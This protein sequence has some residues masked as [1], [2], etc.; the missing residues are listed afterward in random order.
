MQHGKKIKDIESD[1]KSATTTF[2]DGTKETGELIIGAE[3]AHSIVRDY[4]LGN[5]KAALVPSHV[6]A[7]AAIVQLPK[8][9]VERFREYAPHNRM[10]ILFHPHGSFTWLGG[11]FIPRCTY[12]NI[13]VSQSTTHQQAHNQ[14]KANGC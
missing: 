3:G 13:N 11:T 10:F 8:E 2:E 1:G 4:L 7:T 14:A 9:A 5:G 12:S 6:V